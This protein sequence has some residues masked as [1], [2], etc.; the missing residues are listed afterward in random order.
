MQVKRKMIILLGAIGILLMASFIILGTKSVKND[1]QPEKTVEGIITEIK[2]NS[3][4]LRDKNNIE[5]I[6]YLSSDY[7]GEDIET[8]FVEDSL[9]IW[10]LGEIAETYP[11]QITAHRIEKQ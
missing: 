4:L 6:V 9:K 5:Y 3:I 7:N 1:K 11:M 10:F 2:E 8:F